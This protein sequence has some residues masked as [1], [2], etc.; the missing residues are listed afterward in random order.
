[1]TLHYYRGGLWQTLSVAT[2]DGSEPLPGGATATYSTY[3]FNASPP[4]TTEY[5]FS[6]GQAESPRAT[7]TVTPEAVA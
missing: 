4:A 3:S 5:Y 1:M 2:A 6:S 7:V